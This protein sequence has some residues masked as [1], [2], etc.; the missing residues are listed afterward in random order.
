MATTQAVRSCVP[1]NYCQLF[2]NINVNIAGIS[3]KITCKECAMDNCNAHRDF[4]SFGIKNTACNRLLISI[5]IL[6]LIHY[7]FD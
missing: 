5:L 7:F 3:A 4:S 6:S 2:Q 1:V